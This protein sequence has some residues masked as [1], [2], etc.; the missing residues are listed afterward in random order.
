MEAAAVCSCVPSLPLPF[1]LSNTAQKLSPCLGEADSTAMGS[2]KAIGVPSYQSPSRPCGGDVDGHLEHEE[3]ELRITTSHL[4]PLLSSDVAGR[5]IASSTSSPFSPLLPSLCARYIFARLDD[6]R[7][8]ARLIPWRV[9]CD[10]RVL[11]RAQ[12]EV[13]CH[14]NNISA[15]GEWWR[16]QGCLR[17]KALTADAQL[18]ACLDVLAPTDAADDAVGGPER[19]DWENKKEEGL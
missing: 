13:S 16:A 14:P 9:A 11:P 1:S 10:R 4:R 17:Q 6:H 3:V 15:P 18:A 8:I 7:V 5:V 19:E 2:S 12:A